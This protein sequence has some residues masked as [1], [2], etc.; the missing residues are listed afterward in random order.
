MSIFFYCTLFL[1]VSAAD[2][3]GGA[4]RTAITAGSLSR[5]FIAVHRADDQS[6]DPDQ[7]QADN[8]R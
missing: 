7:N 4:A 3:R 8:H 1:L 2:S 6:D 5:F